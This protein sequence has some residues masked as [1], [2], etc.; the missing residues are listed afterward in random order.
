METSHLI[1]HANQ[2]NGFYMKCNTGL[3]C[4]KTLQNGVKITTLGVYNYSL[5]IS[6][7]W[8]KEA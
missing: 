2:I 7:S 5:V 8:T 1:C 4:V 3:N 6:E